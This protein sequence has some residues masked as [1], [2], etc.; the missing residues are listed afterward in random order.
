MD[1]KKLISEANDNEDWSKIIQIARAAKLNSAEEIIFGFKKGYLN[2]IKQSR[3]YHNPENINEIFEK[4]KSYG[5]KIL[6]INFPS[7]IKND[8]DIKSFKNAIENKFIV[9][10]IRN[11]I[12]AKIREF[13]HITGIELNE[14]TYNKDFILRHKNSDKTY[15]ANIILSTPNIRQINIHKLLKED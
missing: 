5:V 13:C 2:T 1:Y 15:D 8:T 4:I 7:L 10:H 9:L 11:T 6:P 14:Y 12:P 3:R